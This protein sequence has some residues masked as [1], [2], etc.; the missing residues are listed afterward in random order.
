MVE[1]LVVVGNFASRSAICCWRVL[2]CLLRVPRVAAL[3]A[4]VITPNKPMMPNA[5]NVRRLAEIPLAIMIGYE[6]REYFEMICSRV[7]LFKLK[8]IKTYS[9]LYSG[10][11]TTLLR[12][13]NCGNEGSLYSFL[14][15]IGKETRL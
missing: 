1:E 10:T 5:I 14:T 7:T 12:G 2:Y 15:F 13:F 3:R 9:A 4:N 8:I 6:D 11:F